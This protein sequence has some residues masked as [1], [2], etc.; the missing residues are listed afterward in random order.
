VPLFVLGEAYAYTGRFA[1]A[2]AAAERAHRAAPWHTMPAGLLAGALTCAGEKERADQIIREMGDTPYPIW[3]RVLY[4]LLCSDIDAAA[5]WYERMIE[6]RDPFAVVFASA[7][8]VTALRASPHW[9][10]LARM[11]NLPGAA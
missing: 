2:I 1:E 11:M 9:P 3:G 7:P 8:Q 6:R 10:R 4:H 5:D